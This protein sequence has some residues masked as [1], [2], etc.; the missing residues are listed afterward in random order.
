VP[1]QRAAAALWN[2]DAHVNDTRA[3]YRANFDIAARRLGN[4]FGFFKPP[5]GFFLWL[6]VGDGEAAALKLWREAGVRTLPGG[7]IARDDAQG[8][9]PGKA[10]LR[11]ALVHDAA[12]TDAALDRVGAIL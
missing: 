7:Y 4:R 9:N 12:T 5:A 11:V 1:I 8:N 3:F 2:D 6:E 10:F